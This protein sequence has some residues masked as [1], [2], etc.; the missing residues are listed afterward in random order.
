MNPQWLVI[1]GTRSGA[2]KMM[3]TLALLAAFRSQGRQVQPFKIGPDCIDPGHHQLARSIRTCAWSIPWPE[4]GDC[5]HG[6]RNCSIARTRSPSF[7][8]SLCTSIACTAFSRSTASFK[9]NH[10]IRN[11][12][13]CHS[14]L[15]ANL[16]SG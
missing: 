13:C 6:L 7:I 14:L 8:S 9:F 15:A 16:S 5:K 3:V 2:G 1:A 12:S 4:S 11:K 10:S